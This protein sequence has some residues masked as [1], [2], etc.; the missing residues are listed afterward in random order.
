MRK[1]L[2]W[3]APLLLLSVIGGCGDDD[4]PPDNRTRVSVAAP[5][6]APSLTDVDDAVWNTITPKA[7]PLATTTAPKPAAGHAV[8]T[9]LNMQ[10][11]RS[12]GSLY[13]RISW[14]DS[15]M[16]VWR[17]AWEILN[18]S[19]VPFDV[20]RLDQANSEDQLFVLFAGLADGAYDTWNWR[21][22]TT[23][24]SFLAEGATF[25]NDSLIVDGPGTTVYET[26]RDNEDVMQRPLSMHQ[27]SSDWTGYALYEEAAVPA[28]TISDAGFDIGDLIPGYILDSSIVS[29][30]AA[31]RGSRWDVRTISGWD[32]GIYTVV[33]SR[34]MNTGFTEDLAIA[35]SVA[36]RFGVLDNQLSINIGGT[37]RAFSGPIWL[38]F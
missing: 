23:G 22:L 14:V 15:T 6:T 21:S 11:A 13:L 26:F 25:R 28:P 16:D 5:A 38:I 27:D 29:R 32:S 7:V 8:P 35:D 20:R 12:G 31:Q 34:P 30:S 33:L 37:S 36:V 24:A 18:D 1:A 17:D 2:L 10:A 3:L 9:S 4:P 19:V